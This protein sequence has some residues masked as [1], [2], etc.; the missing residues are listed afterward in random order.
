MLDVCNVNVAIC[1]TKFTQYSSENQNGKAN[2][3]SG[4]EQRTIFVGFLS[5]RKY[6]NEKKNITNVHCAAVH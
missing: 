5:A 3:M 6:V 2:E 1:G 4:N